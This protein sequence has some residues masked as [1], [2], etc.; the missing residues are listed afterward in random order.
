MIKLGWYSKLDQTERRT[1]W[2]CFAG[3]GLDA[4]DTTIY[5]LVIP[6][7]IATLGFSQAE[8][9]YLATASLA[10]A[11]VG[12]WAAG[13]LADRL[14]RVR[15]LQV[16]I[17][18]VAGFTCLAAFMSDF[19]SL[20]AV[21]F[22]QGLG[23]GGEAAVGG[24]LI[25]EVIRPAL[26]GRVAASVQS[27]YAVGYAISVSLLPV[28]AALFSEEMGWRVFFA[29]GI[30][31]AVLVFFIRRLVPE[32]GIYTE[33]RAAELA[34][35]VP[36]PFW[37]IFT[38]SYL[39]RTIAA[40]I[41]STGIFGGAYVMITW[42][43]SY[44]RIALGLSIKS[45]TGYLAMNILGSLVGP[46]LF[47]WLS[48]RIGRRPAFMT[49]LVLQSSNVAILLLAPIGLDTTIVLSFFLGAFQGAL[50]SGMLPTFA[51]LFPTTIRASGQGFCLGGGR[52]FGSV[53][54]A[55][56]GILAATVPLGTAMG[57]CALCAYGTAFC[58]A[59]FL[60]ET[61]GA[62]LHGKGIDQDMMAGQDER[63]PRIASA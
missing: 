35:T 8:A 50:A 16:T 17:L 52:G 3:F 25:S 5:A 46:L 4:M 20:A 59:L 7:L 1:Y 11:A 36:P 41:M 56:V 54:P 45:S 37:T 58:A 14:G 15:I 2:A 57:I 53:V 51:E 6:A 38:G 21:R 61:A 22:L 12:G 29:I 39:R 32:S 48:D 28:I 30:I 55:T 62:D 63:S 24:V 13:I 47:G 42:L 26:R 27:S 33:A 18:M 34:G 9:G 19:W 43:P 60:P 10:G 40:A 44:L 49:F 31:P 23:Y